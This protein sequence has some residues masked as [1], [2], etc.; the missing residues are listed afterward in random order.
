MVCKRQD[1]SILDYKPGHKGAEPRYKARLVA[2]GYAQLNG[3]DYLESSTHTPH[4]E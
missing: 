1:A 4:P 2:C 3:V